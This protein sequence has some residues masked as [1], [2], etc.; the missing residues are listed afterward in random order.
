M[1]V[2]ILLINVCRRIVMKIATYMC[3]YCSM[4]HEF[5]ESDE[6]EKY[7]CPDC[8]H[9]MWYWTLSEI[10]DKTGLVIKNYTNQ[11]REGNK[12]KESISSKV[13]LE[14]PYCHS[15]DTKKIT[16]VSKAVHTAIFGIF[17]VGR[18]AKNYHCNQCRSDF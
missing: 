16:N 3:D 18:N 2:D 13:I 7:L 10:D 14:C 5:S 6:R 8:G 17:S 12:L 9:E 11:A 1:T 4:A 15:T